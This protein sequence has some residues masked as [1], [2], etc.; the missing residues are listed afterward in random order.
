MATGISHT[1]NQRGSFRFLWNTW[2]R[3]TKVH[4]FLMSCDRDEQQLHGFFFFL[5]FCFDA[6]VSVRYADHQGVNPVS[7]E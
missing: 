5:S 3:S 2:T 6:V 7:H 1:K 4:E